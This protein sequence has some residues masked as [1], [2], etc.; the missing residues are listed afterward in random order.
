M[1]KSILSLMTA[2]LLLVAIPA[3]L[4]AEEKANDA[5]EVTA[6]VTLEVKNLVDRLGEIRT[7]DFS[8]LNSADKKELRKEVRSINSELN[9]FARADADA[10][11]R[12]NA[13]ADAN[14]QAQQRGIYIGGSALV[15]IL[16]VLLL[17]R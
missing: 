8:E 7:M 4:E 10:N 14:A 12:A 11:A 2:F 13:N 15:V 17:L 6:E 9:E 5:A 3:Q 16:L 1:K